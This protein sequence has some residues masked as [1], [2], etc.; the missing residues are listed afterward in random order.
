MTDFVHLHVHTEYSLLDGAC[1]IKKLVARAKELGQTAVAI[2]DHGVMYGVVNFYRAAK[3]EGLKPI[4]GCEVYVAPRTRFDKESLAIDGANYHLVLLCK[5]YEGYQNLIKMVS[6]AFTEGFY[7]KPRVDMDLLSAHSEGLICLSACLGGEIPQYILKNDMD[8]AEKTALRL[9]EIFGAENFYLEL[10]DHLMPDQKIVNRGL[11]EISEKYNIPLVATNDSHYIAK[12]DAEIQDVLLCV[13]T[14]RLVS[15]ENRMRFDGEEFYVKSGDEMA[16]LFPDY[17]EAISNTLKIADA[18]NMDFTFG[19]YNLPV[20]HLP[21]GVDAF[22]ALQEICYKG[23]EKMYP[24]H[25]EYKER[26][27]FEL[28]MIRQMGFVD[29]FLIVSDFIAY[30]KNNGIFVGPGRGSAAGSMVSYCTGIT[31]VDPIKYALFFERFLNPE[32]VSMPDIDIDF[33]IRRRGE[34]IEYVEAK[35]GKDH[36]AQIITFGTMAAKAAI[37]DVG[38]VIGQTYAEVDRVAN[39]I[40]RDLKMTIEKALAVN[41][42]LKDMVDN[43]ERVA[44]LIDIAKRLE[45]TPRHAGTHAAGVVITNNPVD[46]YV[47]LAKNGDSIV[48]QF[49]M[50]TLEELGLLKMDFLG[51]RNLTVIDDAVQEIRRHTKDFDIEKIPDNDKAVMAMLARGETEG[52]FQL[53]SGGMTSVIA[54]LEPQSIEDITA[55]ISLYRPGPM[56]SIPTYIERK[57]DPGKIS[58][59]H[60]LLVNIL[61]VTYGC[62]VY[63]EQVMEVFRVLAGYSLGRADIVRRAMSK[64]KLDVLTKERENFIFGNEAEG[65]DGCVK[66]GVPREVAADIYDEILD[67]ANYA[68]NKAHAVCY[69]IVS[70]MTAYLKCHHPREYFAALISSVMGE[71]KSKEGPKKLAIYIGVAKRYGIQI[72]RPDI[73]HSGIQFSV[74]GGDIRFGLL[75]LKGVGESVLQQVIAERQT[76]GLYKSFVDFCERLSAKGI[77][78]K[79]IDSLIKSGAFDGFSNTRAS[80]LACYERVLDA[81]AKERKSKIDGQMDLFS[82]LDDTEEIVEIENIPELSKDEIYNYEKEAADIYISGH[83]MEAYTDRARA[84]SAIRIEALFDSLSDEDTEEDAVQESRFKNGDK[85]TL[86]GVCQS[87]VTKYTKSGSYLS[88]FTLEDETGGVECLCFAKTVDKYGAYIRDTNILYVKGRLD[89]SGGEKVKLIVEELGPLQDVEAAPEPTVVSKNK[90]P[91]LFLQVTEE[92]EPYFRQAMDKILDAKGDVRVR[93]HMKK[94]GKTYAVDP[95]DYTSAHPILLQ[96]LRQLL[97]HEN[98]VINHFEA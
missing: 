75:A 19:E 53:E 49:E 16:A 51:L 68:F 98:V 76:N 43:E 17:P 36:V 94:T 85:I 73:N 33:C 39:E 10:Q 57:K 37:K 31:T 62:M 38:R 41:K 84:M 40:P 44:K 27:D 83:P 87:P 4:I 23:F 72:L 45:G 32:R 97:G 42:N 63:Q 2:T 20:F 30:A 93:I 24:D 65:L 18:C 71:A 60:P 55:V 69:A 5:N 7:S 92:N 9:R 96:T 91:T 89:I 67:F 50:T 70:Y 58:Y 26:L 79:A 8:S 6:L 81:I 74:E 80:L 77:N 46:A 66:R 34:V 29:Y 1:H 52:V 15:E 14:G 48:A 47:P 12:A 86:A 21:P 22:D 3:K 61:D 56:E 95:K 90:L 78:K 11:I 13:Q 25:P 82:M 59:K 64:K 54:Q 35:Y 28:N 88:F